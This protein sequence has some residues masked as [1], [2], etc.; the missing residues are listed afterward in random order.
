MSQRAV[1]VSFARTPIARFRGSFT[2]LKAPQLGSSAIKGALSRSG[3][4]DPHSHVY[5]ALMGN[6]VSAGIGQAPCRQ[7]GT[8]YVV[9]NVM[10]S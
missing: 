5:E 2:S 1:I 10:N 8:L 3:L 4:E 9:I 6:V 7:A